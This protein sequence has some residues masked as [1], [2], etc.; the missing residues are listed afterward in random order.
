[1]VDGYLF[2]GYRQMLWSLAIRKTLENVII[3]KYLK[4]TKSTERN[5]ERLLGK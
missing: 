5:F 3:I 4:Q 2:H 1:M